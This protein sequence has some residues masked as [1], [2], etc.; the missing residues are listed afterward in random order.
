[1]S[2]KVSLKNLLVLLKEGTLDIE[3]IEMLEIYCNGAMIKINPKEAA[4]YCELKGNFSGNRLHKELV[5][6]GLVKE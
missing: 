6:L 5:K 3:G 4:V 1:M 2:K